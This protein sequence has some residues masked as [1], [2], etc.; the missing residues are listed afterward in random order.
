M[1]WE[2]EAQERDDLSQAMCLQAVTAEQRPEGSEQS[3]GVI[4]SRPALPQGAWATAAV[5]ML[6][7]GC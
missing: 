5:P 6:L 7:P 3:K 2:I 4:A 1:P